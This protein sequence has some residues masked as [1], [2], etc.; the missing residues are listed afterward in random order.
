MAEPSA[1]EVDVA[2]VG[3]GPAGL[4]AAIELRR[5]GVLRVAVLEREGEAGGVPRHCG[6][7]P[8]GWREYGRIL[9]GPAYAARLRADATGLD[10][11]LRTTVTELGPDGRLGLATPEGRKTLQAQR[12][13][14]ATGARETPRSARLVG[15][16]RPVGVTTTG[17]LQ[18]MVY[19][20]NR[21]PFERPLI[22]G[23]ELVSFSAI[24]TCR[25]AGMR[26]VAMVEKTARVVAP[27][28]CALYPRLLGIPVHTGT[29][30][31]AIEGD[32]RVESVLLRG[33]DGNEHRVAC[34][35]VLFT[36]RFVPEASLLRA[37][38][39]AVDSATGGPVVDQTG[40]CRDPA[41]FAAGNLLRPIETAG[42]SHR[43]G[44]LIAATVAE[45]LAAPAAP[46]PSRE[47]AISHRPPVRLVMPQR[48]ALPA[49]GSGLAD[50]Q[51]RVERPV[52]GDL[53]IMSGGVPI[54]RR[55]VSARPEQRLLVPLEGFVLRVGSDALTV[56]FDERAA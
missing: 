15:G 26:P 5:H 45:D 14:L 36:G 31:V 32:A 16:A 20:R 24:L 51:L 17:A 19:L 4:S 54:W 41:Y 35:G 39:L 6:H 47:I 37:S 34:D 11:R 18:A 7:P 1:E 21:A 2:I 49:N 44:R 50:L 3:A 9:S 33:D 30:V 27:W 12:V 22:V 10:I 13:I 43:E 29:S 8:F 25:K 23:T 38:H 55:R 56:E 28:P 53:R 42:W 48:L 46:R 52:S 40:R